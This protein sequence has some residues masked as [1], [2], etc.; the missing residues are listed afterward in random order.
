[1]I[2]CAGRTNASK[3]P[4]LDFDN[5]YSQS[6]GFLH[7]TS[8]IY[9]STSFGADAQLRPAVILYEAVLCRRDA[10]MPGDD[11]REGDLDG[12]CQSPC[13]KIVIVMIDA[14]F[15][16]HGRALAD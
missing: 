2:S 8:S 6:N 4:R 10:P 3:M 1:M 5:G 12:S 7:T 13:I 14:H 11:G 16:G 15:H 9:V